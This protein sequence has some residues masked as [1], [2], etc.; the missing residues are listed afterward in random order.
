MHTWV[1]GIFGVNSEVKKSP[2]HFAFGF[3]VTEPRA[4][5]DLKWGLFGYTFPFEGN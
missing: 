4:P 5:L 3:G 1:C 2:V